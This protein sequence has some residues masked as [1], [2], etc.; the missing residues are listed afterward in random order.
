MII[1]NRDNI[2]NKRKHRKKDNS[3]VY[4]IFTLPTPSYPPTTSVHFLLPPP[5]GTIIVNYSYYPT[6]FIH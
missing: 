2:T 3:K 4:H 6:A 1:E 5:P